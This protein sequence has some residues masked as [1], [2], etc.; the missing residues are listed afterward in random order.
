MSNNILLEGSVMLAP[1]E[2]NQDIQ[3]LLVEKL[4][5]KYVTC[6]INHG[7]IKRIL[8]IHNNY[9]TL[10][11]NNSGNIIFNMKFLVERILPEI[12]MKLDCVVHTIFS[13][14]IF[15]QVADKIKILIP[16][17]TMQEYSFIRDG[18]DE[19]PNIPVF[20]S[21]EK[22]IC[23]DTKLQI[24]I[25]DVKYGKNRYNCIGKLI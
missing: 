4:V 19:M 9:T 22:T 12:G 25:T 21:N 23:K 24:I 10:I 1:D 2:L 8:K 7:Y 15:A 14:G 20:K 18:T 16:V 13:H 5:K 11:D 6:N 3:Q 17:A